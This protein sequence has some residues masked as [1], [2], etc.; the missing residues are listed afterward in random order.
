MTSEFRA[1]AVVA[2]VARAKRSRGAKLSF[3]SRTPRG[4][5]TSQFH[6]T[7]PEV[8]HPT[9][10]EKAEPRA[11]DEIA[12][13]ASP[14]GRLDGTRRRSFGSDININNKTTLNITC[15]NELGERDSCGVRPGANLRH[16][17]AVAV[18]HQIAQRPLADSRATDC[19]V[20]DGRRSAASPAGIP[21]ER[22][23]GG[24][25][26]ISIT[27]NPAKFTSTPP[28][29]SGS[30]F[31]AAAGDLLTLNAR[32]SGNV[33]DAGAAD[34]TL[35][36]AVNRRRSVADSGTFDFLGVDN[37]PN[38]PGRVVINFPSRPTEPGAAS[39]S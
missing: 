4:P 8:G 5:T 1:A 26:P 37:I 18:N 32:G 36:G 19:E 15:S 9:V 17:G 13:C 20:S 29:R 11:R 14:V 21:V 6:S 35:I 34:R 16:A 12:E 10:R 24:R 3:R 2:R 27:D 25:R 38:R 22:L 28:S 31:G 33:C 23:R 7:G 30:G 39:A